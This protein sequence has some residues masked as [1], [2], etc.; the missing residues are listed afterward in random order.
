MIILAWTVVV[1]VVASALFSPFLIG[2][3]QGPFTAEDSLRAMFEAAIV[4]ALAGR[5]LGWW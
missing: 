5:V 3:P 1:V 2:K 4:A